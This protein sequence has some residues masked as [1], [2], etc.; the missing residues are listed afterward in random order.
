MIRGRRQKVRSLFWNL[1]YFDQESPASHEEK[2]RDLGRLRWRKLYEGSKALSIPVL[3]FL[4]IQY[5]EKPVGFHFPRHQHSRFMEFYYVDRGAITMMVEGKKIPLAA[6][7]GIVLLPGQVHE[8]MGDAQ[9]PSNIMT[10]H[11]QS[12]DLVRLFPDLRGIVGVALT[13]GSTTRDFFRFFLESLDRKESAG[14]FHAGVGFLNFLILLSADHR[15]GMKQKIHP[16]ER[17]SHSPFAQKIEKFIGDHVGE[18]LSLSLIAGQM[19]TSVSSLA[20]LYRQATGE[21]VKQAILR[22]RVEKAKELLRE[23]QL[24]VK[25][26]AHLTG[27]Q[28]S[29]ALSTVF[30]KMEGSTP[31][32]YQRSLSLK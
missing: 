29:S 17:K 21:T 31:G 20:H 19:G 10:L 24:S 5:K 13:L 30:R 23:G 28:S 15:K 26:I 16:Q 22:C 3:E 6:Q 32:D 25:E 18:K 14:G 11:F 7:Q 9:V 27:F 2:K 1:R 8:I 4:D 12:K